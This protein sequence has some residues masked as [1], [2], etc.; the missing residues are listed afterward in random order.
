MSDL[1]TEAADKL[2]DAILALKDMTR[3][4][5]THDLDSATLQKYDSILTLKNGR[6]I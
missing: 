3:I 4:V 5:V 1:H 6:I 2:F